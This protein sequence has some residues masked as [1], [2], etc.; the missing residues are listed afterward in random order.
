MARK[1]QRPV[2]AGE[3]QDQAGD[4]AQVEAADRAGKLDGVAGLGRAGGVAAHQAVGHV[5]DEGSLPGCRR[6]WS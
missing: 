1:G 5:A 3:H 2:P 6:A 4:V